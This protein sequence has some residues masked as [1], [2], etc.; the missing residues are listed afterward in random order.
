MA[1]VRLD[2]YITDTGVCSR[3]A[4]RERIR[5][6][7]VCVDGTAVRDPARKIDPEAARVTMDGETLGRE[8]HLYIM[9]HKPAGVLTASRDARRPTVLDAM[10]EPWKRRGLFPVGRLDRDTTGL[11]LLTDDGAFA[12]RVISP[13][14]G[15]SKLY[16]AEVD[17]TPTA[18]DVEAFAAGIELKD[19]TKCLPARLEILG[20]GRVRVEICEGKYHQVKRML[21]SRQL[22]VR[23][24]HREKI[25][26]LELDPELGP[27]GFRML[28]RE[29]LESVVPEALS[30]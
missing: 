12:H 15:V 8:E 6:G 14:S 23:T 24:L 11:L 21:A 22:P 10:P 26:G 5:G 16:Q 1:L 30:K 3:S 2:K 9:L 18:A 7:A 17:G 28:T 13:R 4:A 20:G 19:G 27:G 25:G 29:E